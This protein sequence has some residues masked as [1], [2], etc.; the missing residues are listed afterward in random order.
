MRAVAETGG[1]YVLWSWNPAGRTT[2]TYEYGRCDLFAPD[3]RSRREILADLRGRPLARAL[4]RAWH[5]VANEKLRIAATTPPFE[6][7][8]S[9]PIEMTESRGFGLHHS[10]RAPGDHARMLKLCEHMMTALDAAI[11]TLNGAIGKGAQ[12]A[13][14]RRFLADA[15]LFRHTLLVHR[16]SIG[17]ALAVARKLPSDAWKDKDLIPGIE[18]VTWIREEYVEGAIETELVELHERD[19]A[20][21]LIEQRRRYLERFRGTPFGELV[22]RNRVYTYQLVWRRTDNGRPSRRSP[23]QSDK[24]PGPTTPGGSAGGGSTTGGG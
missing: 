8:G 15:R 14:D 2:V 19:R 5:L 7:R 22:A 9:M 24:E 12:D 17:E 4:T 20:A 23:A 1:R 16:F 11:R 3:L 21:E 6:R 10:W 13:Q 18:S